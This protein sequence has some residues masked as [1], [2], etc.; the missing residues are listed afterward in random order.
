MGWS[1]AAHGTAQDDDAEE[2]LRDRVAELLAEYGVEGSQFAGANHNG[3][4]HE[5][6]SD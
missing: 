6:G 2:E 4:I 3:P 5:E 1:L